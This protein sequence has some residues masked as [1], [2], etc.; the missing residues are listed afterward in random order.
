[1]RICFRVFIFILLISQ[2]LYAGLLRDEYRNLPP[3]NRPQYQVEIDLDF[4][5]RSYKG[6]AQ[7]RFEYPFSENKGVVLRLFANSGAEGEKSLSITSIKLDGK[8]IEFEYK[9]NTSVEIRGEFRAKKIYT[10]S[11]EFE[12][13]MPRISDE[14]SD[15]FLTSLKQLLGLSGQG[16]SENNYGVFGCSSSVC[17]MAAPIP[18]LAKFY[19][20][21]WLRAEMNGIGDY[22]RGDFADYKVNIIS[23]ASVTVVNN[24]IIRKRETM[25]DGRIKWSFEAESVNDIIFEASTN[26]DYERR[27]ADGILYSF[28]SCSEVSH[29]LA[30]LSI[31]I[32]SEAV[33]F[34]SRYYAKYPY[35]ELKIVVVPMTGG[36]GGVEFPALITVGDFLY[37]EIEGRETDG[38]FVSIDLL[39]QMFEFVIVH[40]VAHQWFA[41]LI[42]SDSR[43]EPYLDE[44]AASF[45][46]YLYFIHKYGKDEANKILENQI[47]LNYVMMRLLG[48]KD[49]PI[50]TPIEKYENMFQYAGIIYGKAPLFFV[51]LR[52]LIGEQRFGFLISKWVKERSFKDTNINQLISMFKFNE[53][54]KAPQID[55]L[56]KRWFEGVYGDADIGKGSLRDLLKYVTDGKDLDLDID[57]DSL[58]DWLENTFDMFRQYR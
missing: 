35:N 34:F 6:V 48:Y 25:S 36:A 8:E 5:N 55:A 3:K 45:S 50:N 10:L 23:D 14:D 1:M 29:K 49:Q 46:A 30:R 15:I 4:E 27:E 47:R 31:D 39:T 7:I 52:E 13:N 26:F 24:G 19:G 28:Y 38:R 41:T 54:Q 40:E 9:D 18:S 37:K 56:Y 11:I 44:G 58:K 53:P 51:K 57:L 43:K 42:P 32:A 16:A 21:N 2:S 20:N 22:Q 33:N 17:N 12:A